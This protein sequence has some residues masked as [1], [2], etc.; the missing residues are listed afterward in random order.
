MGERTHILCHMTPVTINILT[1]NRH[2]LTPRHPD[3]TET[4]SA[5]DAKMPLLP[6]TY[7]LHTQSKV[8]SIA[9]PLIFCIAS[10]RTLRTTKMT[11]PPSSRTGDVMTVPQRCQSEVENK[12][13]SSCNKFFQLYL[14]QNVNLCH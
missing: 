3:R 8:S 9:S 6:L 11:P 2:P 5:K 14:K 4:R 1:H 10:P 7:K 12:V 13:A